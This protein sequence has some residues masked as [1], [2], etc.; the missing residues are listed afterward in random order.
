MK[1]KKEHTLKQP[2]ISVIV[3]IYNVE[4]YLEKCLNSIIN[5]TYKNLEIILVDDGSPDNCGKICEEYAKKDNRIRVVHKSNGGLSSA[6]N[7]GLDIANGEYIAF[8][9]S[10]DYIAEN[11]YED[12]INIARKEM[13]DI[14][15][16]SFYYVKKNG[17]FPYENNLGGLD[18]NE[19]LYQFLTDRYHSTI[20][21]KFFK[22]ALF[23]HIRFTNINFEDLFIMPSLILCAQKVSFTPKAYYYY[24]HMNETSLTS[25]KNSN[26]KYG[27]FKAWMEHE[28]LGEQ[29]HLPKVCALSE[30][31]AAR[32]AIGAL[33]VDIVNPV[34]TQEEIKN[35]KE[36]LVK[37]QDTKMGVKYRF[38]G[39]SLKH[40]PIFCKL[41]GHISI[42]LRRKK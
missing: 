42:A 37:K 32:S 3:P 38:L 24:N 19:I 22:A 7:A 31:R 29:L 5:Q 2:L 9:D 30:Y 8:V 12:L 6:R 33:V 25:L 17:I 1:T 14:V 15:I 20:C 34:L 28:R 26:I 18:K 40:C 35:C 36:Y 21:S 4:R 23:E 27:L 41:Y 10:D 13:S 39:W 16:S 11:M